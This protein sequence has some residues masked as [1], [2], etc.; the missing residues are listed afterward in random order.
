MSCDFRIDTASTGDF[1]FVF[2]ASEPIRYPGFPQTGYFLMVHPAESD[3]PNAYMERWDDF[4]AAR[5]ENLVARANVIHGGD[6]HNLRLDRHRSGDMDVY[7]DGGLFMQV[8]DTNYASGLLILRWA[9]NVWHG[10]LRIETPYR[11]PVT[12]V[13]MH[14]G[15]GQ[16]RRAPVAPTEKVDVLS[17]VI[18]GMAAPEVFY[19]TFNGFLADTLH[20]FTRGGG[21]VTTQFVFTGA[22]ICQLWSHAARVRAGKE[23]AFSNPVKKKCRRILSTVVDPFLADH[24]GGR[25]VLGGHS[26]G[27]VEMQCLKGM[28]EQKCGKQ[29]I[30]AAYALAPVARRL[31]QDV[32]V[33]SARHDWMVPLS[34]FLYPGRG[35]RGTRVTVPGLSHFMIHNSLEARKVLADRF[36]CQSSQVQPPTEQKE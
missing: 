28:V 13:G 24:S 4:A 16:A 6:I 2:N 22:H 33:V 9:A 17:V 7:L 27:S 25:I 19:R 5:S 29:V 18:G 11:A 12:L 30:A 21:T 32:A 23:D 10:N 36:A 31:D 14:D 1:G 35:V 20:G 26:F 15:S 3:N 8:R 34:D